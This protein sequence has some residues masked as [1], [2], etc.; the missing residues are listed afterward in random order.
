[1][2]EQYKNRAPKIGEDCLEPGLKLERIRVKAEVLYTDPEE[3]A[4]AVR[5]EV[6]SKHKE[7][8]K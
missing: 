3:Y 1:M 2:L 4:E 6:S 8:E 5:N 7:C